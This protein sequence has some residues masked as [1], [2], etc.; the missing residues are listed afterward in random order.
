M[1]THNNDAHKLG[2]PTL[3]FVVIGRNEGDRLRRCIDSILEQRQSISPGIEA[4]KNDD[5]LN[6]D[7][8]LNLPPVVYVDSG[9]T[10][11]SVEYANSVGSDVIQ[12]DM[13]TRFTAAR[14]RNT[15]LA[16]L[17]E[18]YQNIEYIQFIDGDCAIQPGWLVKAISFLSV[19]PHVAI[20]CGRRREVY[21][22]RT[23]YNALCDM[24]WDTPI[25]DTKSCG[26]DF[27]ARKEAII[28]VGG[29]N[30][31]MIAGEEPEMCFRLRKKNWKI[32]R[33]A[34]EMTSHDAAMTSFRQFW[35]RNKRAGFAYAA[36]SAL[37]ATKQNPYCV[38]E[39]ASI[40]FWACVF[41]IL[42]ISIYPFSAPIALFL[43]LVYPAMAFRI[44]IRKLQRRNSFR[45]SLVYGVLTQIG[46]IPQFFGVTKFAMGQFSGRKT[47]IIEYK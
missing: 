14:A 8:N 43:I 12:L 37:H 17:L 35:L 45:R 23:I 30:P 26:G 4:H 27:L 33:I 7:S 38:R 20:T 2:E 36:R 46:K 1:P 39:V 11:G 16:Y 5:T 3:G 29:F 41:P 25:G 18:K 6:Q 40:C 28:A 19:N 21:P 31:E 13:T 47:A 44:F 22:Q 15:G 34:E 24:E 10:D 9:S 42:I 32:W